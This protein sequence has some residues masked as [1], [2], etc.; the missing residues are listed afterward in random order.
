[1]ISSG[2][3]RNKISGMLEMRR[4]GFSTFIPFMVLLGLSCWVN[5]DYW[6]ITHKLFV[7]EYLRFA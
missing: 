7:L 4:D 5:G 6:T 2:C 3:S 1:M